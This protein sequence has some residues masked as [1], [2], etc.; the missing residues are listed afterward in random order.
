MTISIRTILSIILISI[1]L[2]SCDSDPNDKI[3]KR[4]PNVV[5]IY[6]DDMGYG[7]L[8][9]NGHPTIQTPN[10]DKLAKEGQKWSN[11]Y[12]AS[13]VCSPSRGALL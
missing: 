2:N 6:M 3:T 5:L 7:D 12:T 11:F 8:S 1:I 13:S 10:I 9:F 4:P